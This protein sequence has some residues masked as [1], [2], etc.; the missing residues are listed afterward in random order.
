MGAEAAAGTGGE[1]AGA[2]LRPGRPD[3]AAALERIH[4]AARAFALPGLC[5]PWDE[6]AVAAWPGGTLLARYRTRVM[7]IGGTPFDCPGL[8]EA[9]GEVLHLCV[10]SPWQG[11]D[12][13]RRLLEAAVAAPGSSALPVFRRNLAARRLRE[14][15]GFRIAACRPASA[16]EEGEPD[17]HLVL[18]PHNAGSNREE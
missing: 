2:I 15:R 8:D 4:H 14:G 6:P 10:S 3:D 5:E 16:N 11:R 9:A 18:S 17:L 7:E 13:G 12:I 1:G